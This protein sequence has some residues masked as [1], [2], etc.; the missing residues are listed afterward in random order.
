MIDENGRVMF[1]AS[2][3]NVN[4]Q[5]VSP[6]KNALDLYTNFAK[7][8]S[9]YYTWNPDMHYSIDAFSEGTVAMMINYSWN[10]PTVESKSPKLNFAAAPIPQFNNGN[11]IDFASYWGFAVAKNKVPTSDPY[12]NTKSAT[13]ATNDQRVAEAWKFLT[14][15]TTKPDGTFTAT[16]GTFGF[17]KATDPNFDPAASY[18]AKT[19]EPAARRDLIQSQLS[20]AKLGAFAAGNLIAKSWKESD[21]TSIESIFAQMIDSVNRGQATSYEALQT[22]AQRVQNLKN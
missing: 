1:D 14:Y 9:L 2:N 15:L 6:G 4:G 20:D 11:K 5:N 19:G 3:M 13:L 7:T 16:G 12:G 22:A 21:P 18:L 17:T 8:G 10:M